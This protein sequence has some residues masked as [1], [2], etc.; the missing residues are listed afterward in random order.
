MSNDKIVPKR[1]NSKML[2]DLERS[3]ESHN[4]FYFIKGPID[5]YGN[6][7]IE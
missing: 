6:C 3:P 4:I 1:I 2:H 5:P 7:R